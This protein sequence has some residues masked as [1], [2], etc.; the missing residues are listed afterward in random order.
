MIAE[1]F[2]YFGGGWWIVDGVPLFGSSNLLILIWY[3]LKVY[4]YIIYIYIY[5]CAE[6]ISC[7]I[8]SPSY[9]ASCVF[10]KSHW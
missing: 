2:F 4:V 3:I 6:K 1:I 8:V 7:L 5:I 10:S 9:R